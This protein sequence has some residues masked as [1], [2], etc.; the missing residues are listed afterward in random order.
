MEGNQNYT[1]CYPQCEFNYYFD[2]DY[3]YKCFNESGCPPE[4]KY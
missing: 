3:N 2:E 4:L 1:N